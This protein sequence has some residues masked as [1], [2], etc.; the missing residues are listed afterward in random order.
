M[1][2]QETKLLNQILIDF[3]EQASRNDSWEMRLIISSQILPQMR[4]MEKRFL[5]ATIPDQVKAM[6]QWKQFVEEGRIN[7]LNEFTNSWSLKDYYLLCQQV[8]GHF[9]G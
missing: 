6:D 8:V 3:F 9:E 2:T 7:E 5:E 1:V 4:D